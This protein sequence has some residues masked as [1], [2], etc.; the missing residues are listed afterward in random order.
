MLHIKINILYIK[1]RRGLPRRKNSLL[2]KFLWNFFFFLFHFLQI[3]L[4]F[5]KLNIYLIKSSENTHIWLQ[6]VAN[7]LFMEFKIEW[8]SEEHQK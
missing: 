6:L 4:Q 7:I 5:F 1:I 2:N 8:L 3:V